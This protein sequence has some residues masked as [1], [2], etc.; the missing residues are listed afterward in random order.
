MSFVKNTKF[1]STAILCASVVCLSAIII[2]IMGVRGDWL[3][4]RTAF[5]TINYASQSGVVIVIA[6]IAIFI[7]ARGVK[8]A[9]IMSVLAVLLMIVPVTT[10]YVNQA[11]KPQ[12][13]LPL[14]DISTDTTNPPL[15]NA[16]VPLRP[17]K[18]NTVI[19]PGEVAATRQEALFPDIKPIESFSSFEQAFQQALQIAKN[20][21]WEIVSQDINT[22]MIEAVAS[23]PVFDFKDD[24]AIRVSATSTGSII[25]IRSH[26]RIGRGDRGKNAARVRGFIKQ[27]E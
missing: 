15:F 20:S 21:G 16:V 2:S 12:P 22:G 11:E 6:A 23:T 24:V 25:D 18:S 19:Y 4:I 26:S 10:Y 13:G 9:K 1:W 27:F 7:L 8:S 5:K 14:N 3:G 17:E